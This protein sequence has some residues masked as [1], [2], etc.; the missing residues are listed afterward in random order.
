M[1]VFDK[2]LSDLPADSSERVAFVERFEA[3]LVAA[4][5]TDGLVVSPGDA[6]VTRMQALS[7]GRLLVAYEVAT[8]EGARLLPALEEAV[9]DPGSGFGQLALVD[10]N[11][12]GPHV[13]ESARACSYFSI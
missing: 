2:P 11:S 6:L 9:S 10:V 12:S 8:P 1:V 13:A 4:A 5:A 3:A 7:E